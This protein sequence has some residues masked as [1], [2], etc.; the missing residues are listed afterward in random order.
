MFIRQGVKYEE[1]VIFAVLFMNML[2]PLLNQTL[3]AK[4]PVKKTPPKKVG[5]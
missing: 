5:E 4:K 2:T 1:G 3:K